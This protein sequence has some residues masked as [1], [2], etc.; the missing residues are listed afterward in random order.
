MSQVSS[1]ESLSL[2]LSLLLLSLM[3]SWLLL[4]LLLLLGGSLVSI[5]MS[6]PLSKG[7]YGSEL[8]KAR[9]AACRSFLFRQFR[10][11]FFV[12][13]R[14]AR[15]HLNGRNVLECWSLYHVLVLKVHIRKLF[16]EF[17]Y[18]CV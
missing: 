13:T 1:I 11:F 18:V 8:F 10:Q 14:A 9:A 5:V 7:L 6:D 3:S 17:V 4:L 16:S 2:Y 12:R 15:F